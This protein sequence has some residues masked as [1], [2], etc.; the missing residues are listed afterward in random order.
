MLKQDWKDQVQD[1]KHNIKIF[2]IYRSEIL[3]IAI[4]KFFKIVNI[5]KLSKLS[6]IKKFIKL[7]QNV[8]TVRIVKNLLL[9]RKYINK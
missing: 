6:K 3:I 8:K 1:C 2:E 9:K 5:V 7:F 4:I